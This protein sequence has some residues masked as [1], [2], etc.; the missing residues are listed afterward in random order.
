GPSLSRQVI[1]A[2]RVL[3]AQEAVAT[4]LA[5]ELAEDPRAAAFAVA[6]A[7]A[8]RDPLALRL[9]KELIARDDAADLRGERLAEALLYSRRAG[10]P[11][12]G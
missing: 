5:V 12:Q 4:G 3:D 1:L 7:V 6:R 8:A 9:A 10:A 11:R 2:G